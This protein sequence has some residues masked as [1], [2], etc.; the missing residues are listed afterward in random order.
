MF[1]QFGGPTAGISEAPAA[2]CASAMV[3]AG[4]SPRERVAG[5]GQLK[6]LIS[7]I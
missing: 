3:G 4:D 1:T 2:S 6:N 7:R 5:H